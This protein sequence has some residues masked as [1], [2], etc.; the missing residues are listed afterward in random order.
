MHQQEIF[1]NTND[2][3]DN[4]FRIVITKTLIDI[5]KYLIPYGKTLYD[6]SITRPDYSLI[7]DF[8]QSNMIME[9]LNYDSIELQNFLA[10]G[11]EQKYDD[12]GEDIIK[13]DNTMILDNGILELLISTIFP[14][15]DSNYQDTINYIN[16]IKNRAIL[17]TR[18]EDV[19]D[20]NSQIR[21]V[22]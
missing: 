10:N 13:L 6:F 18:N 19:D 12:I 1:R 4:D 11:E 16:Y 20:I 7:E 8:Q 21:G 3:N 15:L 22:P 9:E 14:N 5:E 2:L 17:T